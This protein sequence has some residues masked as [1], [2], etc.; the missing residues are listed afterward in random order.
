MIHLSLEST[1]SIP[2]LDIAFPFDGRSCRILAVV[3]TW[4]EHF[5]WD[6]LDPSLSDEFLAFLRS[7]RA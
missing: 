4:V 3:R 5:F 1:W 2:R 7:V 6:F